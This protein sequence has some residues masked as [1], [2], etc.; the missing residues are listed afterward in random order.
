MAVRLATD[1][2]KP[3]SIVIAGLDP[4]M[5]SAGDIEAF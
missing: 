5:R 2:A 4:A 3:L 1:R